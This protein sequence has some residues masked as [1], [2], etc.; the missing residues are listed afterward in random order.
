MP[1]RG[2]ILTKLCNFNKKDSKIPI[3]NI[4]VL[5][6][7]YSV[8]AS[9]WSLTGNNYLHH[10]SDVALQADD[11]L[12][13]SWYTVKVWTDPRIETATAM[14]EK[15]KSYTVAALLH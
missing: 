2:N 9:G 13:R 14:D 5:G 12:V 4:T 11:S 3:G 6:V 1:N 10:V 8:T 7:I 15:I